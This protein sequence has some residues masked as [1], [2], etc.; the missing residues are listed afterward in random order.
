MVDGE[1]GGIMGRA[2]VRLPLNDI[3]T[4]YR[5]EIKG[6]IE[7]VLE[8]DQYPKWSAGME[9]FCI[10][11][12]TNLL[13][14]ELAIKRSRP[15]YEDESALHYKIKQLEERNEGLLKALKEYQNKEPIIYGDN[16]DGI[17]ENR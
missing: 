1:Q 17:S 8:G 10:V 12:F 3:V 14:V 9:P 5:D 6:I 4:T 15:Y 16:G 13:D 11:S 7:I 2:L